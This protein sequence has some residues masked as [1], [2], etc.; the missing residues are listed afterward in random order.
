VFFLRS[1]SAEWPVIPDPLRSDSLRG[2]G[3]AGLAPFIGRWLQGCS[4]S[5]TQGRTALKP[6]WRLTHAAGIA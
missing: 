3:Q 1:R 4:D 2:P 5:F 6:D